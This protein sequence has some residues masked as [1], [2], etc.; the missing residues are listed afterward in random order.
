LG[1]AGSSEIGIHRYQEPAGRPFRSRADQ[2]IHQKDHHG[3]VKQGCGELEQAKQTA[4][5]LKAMG[6]DNDSI[7]KAVAMGV[8][9]VREWFGES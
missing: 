1:E 4:F 2:R 3:N 8:S 6:M 5:N 9:V 7:A